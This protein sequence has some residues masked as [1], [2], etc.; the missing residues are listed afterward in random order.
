VVTQ[1]ILELVQEE[2]E[3]D[4]SLKYVRDAARAHQK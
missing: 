3:I 2:M 4:E 1:Q